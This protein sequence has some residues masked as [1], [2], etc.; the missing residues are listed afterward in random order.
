VAN[1]LLGTARRHRGN[2]IFLHFK[3][4]ST[5][6]EFL[7]RPQ[8]HPNDQQHKYTGQKNS[9][10]PANKSTGVSSNYHQSHEEISPDSTTYFTGTNIYHRSH[11]SPDDYF[12]PNDLG[13]NRLPGTGGGFGA[14]G[15][16]GGS[17]G[18]SRSA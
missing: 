4:Y 13:M 7:Y 15:A 11:S 5:S 12:F 1:S 10:V 2:G 14:A 3:I 18:A 6:L 8:G 17:L 9:P 16:G